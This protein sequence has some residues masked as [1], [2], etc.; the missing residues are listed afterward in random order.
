MN[1]VISQVLGFVVTIL[2]VISMQLK[3]IRHTLVCTLACNVTGAATYVFAGGLSGCGIYIIAIVQCIVYFIFSLRRKK[4]PFILAMV[5]LTGYLLCSF[6]TYKSYFDIISA[7]AAVTCAFALAQDKASGFRIFMIF[8]GILWMIYDVSV[9]AYTMIL[10]HAITFASA[11][12]GIIR[13]DI[14]RKEAKE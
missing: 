6:A 9:A 7:L 3:D 12:V 1:F 8:N 2:V 11:L 5:F 10:S 13:L 14:C 4:A